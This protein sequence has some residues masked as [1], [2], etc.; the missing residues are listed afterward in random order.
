MST[1]L[2]TGGTGFI[3]AHTIAQLLGQKHRVRTTLRNL[4]R[5]AD[6]RAMLKE[7]GTE[8]SD[9]L[10]FFAADLQDDAGWSRAV[11]GCD[12]V[13]HIA[14][15]FPP[16]VPEHEDDLIVPAREGTLRV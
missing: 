1:I 13:H 8:P 4:R 3:A 9:Q 15:P 16:N 5:E 14:S 6:V 7:S 2:V 11:E 10:S 12:Y